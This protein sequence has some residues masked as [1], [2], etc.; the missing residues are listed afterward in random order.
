MA[1]SLPASSVLVCLA[2]S[3]ETTSLHHVFHVKVACVG[4]SRLEVPYKVVTPVIDVAA[5]CLDAPVNTTPESQALF[6]RYALVPLQL[7]PRGE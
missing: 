1:Y 7:L 4:V 5:S 2:A 3:C 6:M